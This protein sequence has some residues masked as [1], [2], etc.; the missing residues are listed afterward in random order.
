MTL[1]TVGYGD[2]VPV[3]MYYLL[4][5]IYYYVKKPLEIRN[6]NILTCIAFSTVYTLTANNLTNIKIAQSIVMNYCRMR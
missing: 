6:V 1:S 4:L 3:S 2:I 5:I